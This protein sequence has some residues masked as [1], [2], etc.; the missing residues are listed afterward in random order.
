MS[1]SVRI[2]FFSSINS[3]IRIIGNGTKLL[4]NINDIS[5]NLYYSTDNYLK[6]Y[7]CN[8]LGDV[9]LFKKNY[10]NLSGVINILNR[11]KKPNSKLLTQQILY[12]SNVDYQIFFKINV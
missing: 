1:L 9:K 5:K 2:V 6:N 10:V 7:Y 8:K 11:A 3:N 12:Y 4:F